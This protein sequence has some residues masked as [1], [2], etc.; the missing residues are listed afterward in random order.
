MRAAIVLSILTLLG[1]QPNVPPL[2]QTQIAQ[3]QS[4]IH[5]TE[6]QDKALRAQLSRHQRQLSAAYATFEL[7]EK[8]IKQLQEEIITLQSKLLANYHHLQVKL[9][10][11][12]GP[13]RF[14]RL[15]QRIDRHLKSNQSKSQDTPTTPAK[16]EPRRQQ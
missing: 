5:Q 15:K 7:D 6:D 14:Q 9:R 16:R 10:Q 11:I 13:Q 4:L 2:S 12:V 1:A 3:I 8:Q